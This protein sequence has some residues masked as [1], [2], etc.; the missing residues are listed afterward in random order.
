MVGASD[1]FLRLDIQNTM[2]IVDA[3]NVRAT[4]ARPLFD[5]ALG[6]FLFHTQF[7]EPI[8][9]YHRGIIPLRCMEGKQPRPLD[10]R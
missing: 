3:R 1:L 4:K 2:I 9:N 6:E 5:F 7:A 8:T 10:S